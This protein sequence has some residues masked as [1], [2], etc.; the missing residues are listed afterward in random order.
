MSDYDE[1]IILGSI[2]KLPER[3]LRKKVHDVYTA[4]FHPDIII[5]LHNMLIHFFIK[6]QIHHEPFDTLKIRKAGAF[7]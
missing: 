2:R 3:Q 4:I 7:L 5:I 6:F 1:S